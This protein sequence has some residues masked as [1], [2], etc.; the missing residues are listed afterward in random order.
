MGHEFSGT[1]AALGA[2]A[3]GRFKVGDAVTCNPMIYC[4]ECHFCRAGSPQHCLNRSLVGAHRPGAFAQFVAVPEKMV[5]ALPEGMDL[6]TGS[7]VEPVAV[8]Q[9]I[10][11]LAGPV[12]GED[13]LIV[14]AGPIGLLALQFM[15]AGKAGRVF[16][17]D[18]DRERLAM[19]AD[20]GAE[21]I[22]AG[23]M[24]TVAHIKSATEGLGVSLTV[25]AVGSAVTRAQAVAATR[26]T[27]KVL[28][29]GL[30]EEAS[31]M[32]AS[33]IIRREIDVLGVFCYDSEDFEQAIEALASGKVRLDPWIVEAD[34]SEGG[35]WFERLVGKPGAVSKVLLVP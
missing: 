21:I 24:D 29:S 31:Q 7:L 12:D 3:T 6:H 1:I 32:P 14:G 23:E 4:G 25:D 20:L 16:I 27:G 18:L 33:E 28:L 15:Q 26:S 10:G 35:S 34:L 13:V 19:A 17:A 5:Y 22:D 2:N 9:R 8:A 11:K 30:H